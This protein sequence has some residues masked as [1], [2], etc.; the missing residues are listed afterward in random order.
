[1]TDTAEPGSRTDEALKLLGSWAA[2]AD[3]DESTRASDY[4]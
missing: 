3:P 1:L 2:T 4:S